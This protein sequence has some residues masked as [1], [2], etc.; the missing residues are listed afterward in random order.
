[1]P[2]AT[3]R[4]YAAVMRSTAFSAPFFLLVYGVVRWIDGL[5]GKHHDGP[6]WTVGHIGFLASMALF[7]VLA[8][9][10]R[11]MVRWRR[12]ATAGA[13]VASAGVLGFLW[14]T[15][16]DLGA[17]LP[18]PGWLS[19]GGP[20]VFAL[21]MLVLQGL[22]VAAG[23]LPWWSPLLFVTGYS[24]ISVDLGLLPLGALLLMG[25]FFPLTKGASEDHPGARAAEVHESR[26][27]ALTPAGRSPSIEPGRRG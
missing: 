27:G 8:F 11:A 1:M 10:I 26:I 24:A 25:S 9:E 18:V 12:T 15:A 6:A 22:A 20:A 23:R 7:A 16:T 2:P 3:L 4:Q 13:V 19:T 17:N 14:V 5:N 21:G